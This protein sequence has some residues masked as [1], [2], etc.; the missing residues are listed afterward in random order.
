MIF[1]VTKITYNM[2]SCT[3][4]GMSR[5]MMEMGD[6]DSANCQKSKFRDM[7]DI[8]KILK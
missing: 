1:D 5:E 8:I 6:R 7:I 3:I 4:S 2:Y